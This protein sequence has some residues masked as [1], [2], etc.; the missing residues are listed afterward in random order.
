MSCISAVSRCVFFLPNCTCRRCSSASSTAS[1]SCRLQETNRCWQ[2]STWQS[3]TTALLHLHLSPHSTPC[4]HIYCSKCVCVCVCVCMHPWWNEWEL[5]GYNVS[6]CIPSPTPTCNL[7]SSAPA[8]PPPP[9]PSPSSISQFFS[10]HR[11][12]HWTH[13]TG[14]QRTCRRK[15][16]RAK[17][18]QTL[19]RSHPF[20]QQ[21]P[22]LQLLLQV[23]FMLLLHLFLRHLQLSHQALA[24]LLVHWRTT[25][26]TGN[27][28]TQRV[29]QTV[30]LTEMTE[31]YHL[32]HPDVSPAE[33][34]SQARCG[35][36]K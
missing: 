35:N 1:C 5:T 23:F 6:H 15:M 17:C 8:P 21:F 28:S 16:K 9:T 13:S 34:Q 25:W 31:R 12:S 20:L 33:S 24:P 14:N 32:N 2:V 7:W 4:V 27:S 30:S 29:V 10:S 36:C 22:G 3:A 19:N 11:N 18:R 26:H